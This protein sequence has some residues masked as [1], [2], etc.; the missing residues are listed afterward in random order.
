[1]LGC[2][3]AW[4]VMGCDDGAGP[5]AR[6]GDGAVRGDGAPGTDAGRLDAG[7]RHDQGAAPDAAALDA[8][9]PPPDASKA[10]AGLAPDADDPTDPDAGPPCPRGARCAPIVVAAFPFVDDGDTRAAPEAA[11]DRWT[12]CAP[13]TDEGGGE[14][15]YRVEVPE[16]G[17]LSLEVDDA[18][19]DGVDVDVHLLDDLAADA[20]VA[21][22]NRAVQWPVGP[23]AWY[24]AVD[25]WVNGAG[26][27]LPGPYRLTI[28]FRPV[29][30]D[31]CAT[32]PVDLRMFWRECAAG[33]DCYVADGETYLRTPA[34][35]PVV[36]E[37]HLV[38]Q[39]DFDDLGGWPSS[40]R[41]GLEAHY[42]RTIDATGY[43]MS[44][45]EPW[46]PAGEG[47][48]EWGQGSTGRPLPVEDEAWYVNMYWRERPAPGT[49]MIARNPAN[50]R[51]VVLA[52]G[53]ETGPGANTA[54]GGVT[55]EVHDWLETGH[56]D[57]LLLGFAAD[58]ALPLG[59][60]ECE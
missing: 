36:K 4:A 13:D 59:P 8:D 28:D 26:E 12:P 20:C 41:E 60:I 19:G 27:A 40:G 11:V 58:D 57:A 22:D 32:R 53:Y 51:A 52:A 17:L 35:G 31:L 18:P 46:A 7:P 3:L 30:D 45:T 42:Q 23:G 43:R 55:E 50:G 5:T 2:L 48:S 15:Y 49:R 1:M 47:G 39:D 16:D 9:P 54:I 33:I 24:V 29:G 10:D 38:T 56:R 25:T 6:L 21:R 34:V 14:I 44:R 37:A